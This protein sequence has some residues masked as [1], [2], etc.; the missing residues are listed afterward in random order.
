[1][2]TTVPT[3]TGEVNTTNPAHDPSY[4]FSLWVNKFKDNRD[5]IDKTQSLLEESDALKR[6]LHLAKHGQKAHKRVR[7]TA[8]EIERRFVC[9]KCSRASSTSKGQLGSTIES[10]VTSESLPLAVVSA[11]MWF[12]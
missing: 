7:R 10:I 1:M 4:F 11:I 12:F 5:L 2:E 3:S 9:P 8:K 6:R